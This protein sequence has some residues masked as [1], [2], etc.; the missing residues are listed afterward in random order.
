MADQNAVM[1][2]STLSS[3]GDSMMEQVK[4]IPPRTII[5]A[6]VVFA[7]IAFLVAYVLYYMIKTR[8]KGQNGVTLSDTNVPSLGTE[9]R[10]ASGEKIPRVN[11]GRRMTMSFWIYIHNPSMFKGMYRHVLHRGQQDVA[12]AT[13]VVF[14]DKDSTA[15]YVRFPKKQSNGASETGITMQ[16]PYVDTDIATDI[17]KHGIKID[18]IPLQ[19]WVY[20][21]VVVNEEVNGGTIYA[22]LDA[23]LVKTVTTGS[24]SSGA[25]VD[26]QNLVLDAPGDI[27]I[28]GSPNDAMGP[29]FSGLVGKVTFFNYDLNVK[30]IYN[31]YKKGPINNMLSKMGLPAYGL[32]S[33]VY[34]IG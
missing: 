13:P 21:T 18:Y 16:Q 7:A 25:T 22:Y 2:S 9:L 14:L 27:W 26:I 20:V 19:R 17:N 34:R 1:D 30:D 33:P 29:G 24:N 5:L 32:R 23:E 10:K 28:G 12:G 8:I 31:E 15:L 3:M 6:L 4:S 11:N